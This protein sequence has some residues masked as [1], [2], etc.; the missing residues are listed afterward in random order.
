MC[1]CELLLFA[2]SRHSSETQTFNR[3]L[4]SEVEKAPACVNWRIFISFWR[5]LNWINRVSFSRA[6]H[7]S[8]AHISRRNVE[9]YMRASHLRA[10]KRLSLR[11]GLRR[12][13]ER[14]FENLERKFGF[15]SCFRF[16]F[17]LVVSYRVSLLWMEN[18]QRFAHFSFP[19]P[20]DIDYTLRKNKLFHFSC[21]QTTTTCVLIELFDFVFL[22]ICRSH[23]RFSFIRHFQR[24]NYSTLLLDYTTENWINGMIHICQTFP[25]PQKVVLLDCE[26]P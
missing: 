23:F 25:T 16:I 3:A 1:Y 15:L 18:M 7:P 21:R 6:R 5:K 9:V 2:V 10:T 12:N 24:A 26:F 8:A 20:S 13:G 22:F 4:S 19:P 11:S 17:S 14:M